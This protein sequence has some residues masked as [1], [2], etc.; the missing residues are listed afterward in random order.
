[1]TAPGAGESGVPVIPVMSIGEVGI[2]LLWPISSFV[3]TG[4][5]HGRGGADY[6]G[7]CR[8]DCDSLVGGGQG[9]SGSEGGNES[10]SGQHVC[11]RVTRVSEG[12]DGTKCQWQKE[13]HKNNTR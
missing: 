7:S 11:K 2:A 6:D 5:S 10:Y 13:R 3:V 1:M 4:D 8:L 9:S 12:M